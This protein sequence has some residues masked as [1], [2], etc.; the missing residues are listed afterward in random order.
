MGAIEV[1]REWWGRFHADMPAHAAPA[2]APPVREPAHDEPEAEAP[3]A[4]TVRMSEFQF[5]PVEVRVK[6]RERVTCVNDDP[7][8]HT[9]TS[10][11]ADGPLQ[12]GDVAP[13]VTFTRLRRAGRV[14]LPL[15]PAR[16]ARERRRVDGHDGHRRR[17]VR[18]ARFKSA[19]CTHS[20][21]VKL[22]TFREV[23]AWTE[24]VPL[25]PE[26]VVEKEE[27]HRLGLLHQSVHLLLVDEAGRLYARRRGED[28]AR[29]PGLYTSTVSVHVPAGQ[30]YADAL[31]A[32]VPAGVRVARV[33]EFRVRDA[34][35]N[36]VCALF[37]STSEA[38]RQRLGAAH[39]ALTG[40]ALEALVR[41][42]RTTP[43]L[44]AAYRRLHESARSA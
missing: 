40:E 19:C 11:D 36:E 5:A 30:S 9:V 44:A 39:A 20:R 16:R 14:P 1:G 6:V 13:G 8:P 24:G 21:V 32:A 3:A 34:H 18:R 41:E 12:S 22:Q 38:M 2:A 4:A 33:G 35:E 23:E 17:R 27:A 42:G 25:L 26:R 28:D 15:R 10:E 37:L 29:Y 31:L 43:H 7:T